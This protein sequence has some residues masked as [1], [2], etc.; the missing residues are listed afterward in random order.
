VRHGGVLV[1][2]K[3]FNRRVVGFQSRS[4]RH[5]GTLGK[6]LTC[7]CLW[8]FGV[9]LKHSIRAVS[10]ALLSSGGLEEALLE[11]V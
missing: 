3:P 2:S 10:G 7:S 5:A 6:S 8:R 11:M 1:E 9:K 4:N